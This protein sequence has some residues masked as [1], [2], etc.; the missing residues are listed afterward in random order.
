[1]TT[2]EKKAWQKEMK[3]QSSVIFSIFFSLLLISAGWL[4]SRYIP[5]L[6]NQWWMPMFWM[7]FI[8]IYVLYSFFF[9]LVPE[10]ILFGQVDEGMEKTVMKLGQAC[11][12]LIQYKGFTLNR[13]WDIVPGREIHLFGG[14]RWV[15]IWPIYYIFKYTQRWT[16]VRESGEA[17][18]HEEEL[19]S[20]LLKEKTYH[21][22][23]KG[24]EDKDGIAL[25][26]DIL[27]TL[28]VVNPYKALFGPHNYLEQVLNRTRPLFREYVRKY[29]FMELSAQKQR[30][31]GEL[32][33]RLEREGMVN[34]FNEDGGLEVIGEFERDYGTR[35]KDGG[36][37]MKRIT[38]PPEYQE[39]QTSKYLSEREAERIAGET[40]GA[41]VGMMANSRGITTKEIQE[42]INK[43]TE[44]QKEFR[45]FCKDTLHKKMAIDGGSYVQIDVSGAG[46][47]EKTLLDLIAAWTRIPKGSRPSSTKTSPRVVKDPK[48]DKQVQEAVDTISKQE[49]EF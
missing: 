32:W 11:K 35:V 27:L 8:F 23:L 10:N 36:I 44:L 5:W 47:A 40:I 29:T 28:R 31:G 17:V 12:G 9:K 19:D 18:S 45:D 1:M 15:G 30:A 46:D 6:K 26:I 22:E 2:D 33:E 41:V 3:R 14:L 49:E 37:E 43:N 21:L 24:A 13:D 4:L 16:S 48:R 38:P 7:G 20:L 39:A 34:V 25:D 42:K